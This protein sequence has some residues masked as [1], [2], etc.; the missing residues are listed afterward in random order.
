MQ[1]ELALLMLYAERPVH[2]G[3]GGSS[4]IADLPIQRE[5]P[6]DLPMI[7]SSAV[8]NALKR[9][10]ETDESGKYK[11][12]S[13]LLFGKGG[14]QEP[15]GKL[16]CSD[17]RLLLFPVPSLVGLF[18]YTTCDF[19]LQRLRR[20]VEWVTKEAAAIP[21]SNPG[22]HALF[23]AGC[24]LKFESGVKMSVFLHDTHFELQAGAAKE[25]GEQAKWGEFAKKLAGLA[26]PAAGSDFWR[27]KMETDTVLLGS[28][29]FGHF[30]RTASAVETHIDVGEDGIVKNGPWD[31]EAL[32]AESLLY[33][34]L[35]GPADRLYDDQGK[36]TEDAN[37]GKTCL[38]WV[39][40]A[41]C[42][43]PRVQLGGNYS[44]G[45]G[46]LRL[47]LAAADS[48]KEAFSNGK[49]PDGG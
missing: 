12:L 45:Q 1:T 37:A 14:D 23:P 19:V 39:R 17:A 26:L 47:R 18:G 25:N 46:W 30:T 33:A 44:T 43:G 28:T 27:T 10:L 4:D 32:P 48:L 41:L 49:A 16:A 24:A 35:A 29:Y 38:C 13:G 42:G 31:E 2:A 7:Q 6:S 15:G 34:V 3:A 40:E 8:K 11:P 9:H 20:D 5:R 21:L 36:P 22:D